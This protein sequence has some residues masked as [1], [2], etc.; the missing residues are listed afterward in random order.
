MTPKGK[1]TPRRPPSGLFTRLLDSLKDIFTLV[2]DEKRSVVYANVS[3]LEHFGL[4]WHQVSGRGCVNLGSPFLGTAGEEAGFCP[5]E[6]GP[7]FPAHHILTR[8]VDGQKLVYEGVFYHLVDGHEGTWTVCTFRDVTHMFNLESQVRQLDE[9]ERSLVQASIDGIIVNDLLGNVLIFNEGASRI[10]GYR[11]EE[12]IGVMKAGDFY[13]DNSAHR[14][15]QLIY[16]PGH[17]GAGILENYETLARHQDGSLVPIWLS[18]RILRENGREVGVVGFF[19]D[20]RER[21]RLEED[22]LRHERLVTL[23]KMVAHI[24]H[25][26]KNPLATIGGFAQQ[27]ERQEDLPE[28]TRRKIKI[29]HEEVQR[30]EKFLTDLSSFTRTAPIQKSPGDILALIQ[31]VAAFMEA[32]FKERGVVLELQTSEKIPQFTFDPGQMRQVFINLFKNALEA[33]PHGGVLTVSAAVR[34]DQLV[35]ALADTGQGIAPEH[36]KSLFTPFFSTKEGGTGLGLT[37]CRGLIDQ[38]QGEIA[39]ASEVDRGTTCTIRLPLQ[40]S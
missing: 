8:E 13:P 33:M 11:P 4:E 1:H 26:I 30:L 17:G 34:E 27:C 3:F 19:R 20:L 5:F 6:L 9:L 32:G 22:L 37:I 12:V 40:P 29:I 2:L 14:I 28:A 10:L 21:K 7:Y 16:C 15:K 23:G 39:I 24:S 25:E 31:E 18:A 38:H 35:L 36:L